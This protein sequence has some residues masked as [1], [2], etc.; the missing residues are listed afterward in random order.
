[1][2]QITPLR[3]HWIALSFLGYEKLF[4]K[5]TMSI[6]I[7]KCTNY[8]NIYQIR[9]RQFR[10]KYYAQEI[11]F[12]V[13]GFILLPNMV[14]IYLFM[15]AKC[16]ILFQYIDLK[17][18]LRYIFNLT[19]QTI[20]QFV[21]LDNECIYINDNIIFYLSTRFYSIF[22]WTFTEKDETLFDIPLVHATR[23]SHIHDQT[24]SKGLSTESKKVILF[25]CIFL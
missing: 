4:R 3:C 13:D 7:Y 18:E 19:L 17:K 12:G 10:N 20:F 15:R 1:M 11:N 16:K 8:D 9:K 5:W 24:K 14:K 25:L 21:E 23:P 6:Y 22:Q 2:W